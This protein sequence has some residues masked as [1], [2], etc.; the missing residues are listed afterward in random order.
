MARKHARPLFALAL[1]TALAAGCHTMPSGSGIVPAPVPSELE[2]VCLPDY[3]VEPPDILLIEAV[4]AIP[5]PPYRVEP[6]DVLFIQIH[7]PVDKDNPVAGPF[8]VEPDGTVNLGPFYGGSV[9]LAGK[10]IPEVKLALERHLQESG[11]KAKEPLVTVS[12]AQSRA[13]QRISGP[14]LVRPDGTI[15]LG[16]YGSVRVTGLTL[17]EVRQ[18]VETQLS[19][20][21]LNPEVSVD[22][23]SYNSKLYYV[24][25]DGGGLGQTVYR[26]PVTG[27]DTV[28]DA[29]SQVNGLAPVSSKDR[30]WVSRPAP[31]GC[32]HQ[33]LPVDWRAVSECGDTASNY[34]LMPGD[35]VFVAS[36]PLVQMDST[37]AR[38]IS[39]IERMLGVTLLGASTVNQIRTDPNRQF[40]RFNN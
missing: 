18:A 30:I 37:L 6:L 12:L 19:A 33:I 31:I 28:L 17:P 25:L 24:I 26:L 36:Y 20:Y 22:V 9:N 39:P 21:L 8:T 13:G 3:R 35:R 40:G 7:F 29:I 10:T 2:K 23:Q 38:V 11:P 16:T 4:R 14:H 1:A 27:N 5:K 15:A 34:Q 32:A